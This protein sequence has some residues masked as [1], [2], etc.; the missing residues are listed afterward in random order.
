MSDDATPDDADDAAS[1]GADYRQVSLVALAALALVLTAALAPGLTGGESDS[2][3]GA[4]VDWDGIVPDIDFNPDT[5]VDGSDD[6]GNADGEPG[7]GP[8]GGFDWRRLLEWLNLDR[9]DDVEP[10]TKTD[11]KPQCVIM[12]DREPVPGSRLTATIRYEGEPLTET[13]VWFDERRVGETDDA[14]RVTGEVPYVEELVIRVGTATDATCR[15]GTATSLPSSTTSGSAGYHSDDARQSS[16]DVRGL[17]SPEPEIGAVPSARRD[18]PAAAAT[19]PTASVAPSASSTPALASSATPAASVQEESAGNATGS[20][21]VD[22]EVTIDVDGEPYPGE[23]ITIDAA[24]EDVPMREATVSVDGTAVGETDG[25]GQATVRVP[26]D[27]TDTFEIGVARGDFAGTTTVDVLLLEAAFAPAGIAPIPGSPGAVEATTNGEPVAGATVTV[28]G[29][30]VGATD[31]DGRLATGLPLDPTATV[32]V[33]TERQ[34]ASVSLVGAY[35][36]SALVLS[37]IILGLMALS[38]R[39]AGR[40]GP[41]AVLGGTAGVAAVLVAEAFYGQWAGIAVL[42]G[43]CLLALAVGLSRSGRGSP[44]LSVRDCSSPRDWLDRLLSRLVALGLGL[45]DRLEVLLEWLHAL[46][47]AVH[48]WV[49]SLPRSGRGLWARFAAWLGTVP[50]RVR[51]GLEAALGTVRT[52]PLRAIAA[53]VGSVPLI[54]GGYVVD[55]VRGAVL[56]TAA[57]AA[58]GVMAA[59]TDGDDP[60]TD[61]RDRDAEPDAETATTDTSHAAA[62]TRSFRDLWRAF[63]RQVAPGRWRTRT[64]GEIER[65]ALSKGYPRRPVRKLT[66]L[67]RE[68]EYGGR[69][70]SASRRERAAEAYDAVE[71]ARTAETEATTAEAAAE[72]DE[73]GTRSLSPTDRSRDPEPG[74]EGEP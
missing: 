42:G 4:D 37:S 11:G 64:P 3:P 61:A 43:V 51:S 55:G 72:R 2:S 28:D 19:V 73:D 15:A 67:F 54:A 9:N 40:R 60:Q 31:A 18:L 52:L 69:P 7:D 36:G 25:S 16:A 30:R 71:R 27:G 62:E 58:A 23:T 56:V 68:V 70:R 45:V 33:S 21:A 35:G 44:S 65:R 8:G 1:G 14:G 6:G 74:T 47:G 53:G 59:R 66:T 46:A 12:L 63:A 22:G 50:G 13:P 48:E 17:G 34:T 24:V 57:L 41:M 10:P 5:D 20:Y 39:H 26:D 29:E 38:Y 49:R 32:T